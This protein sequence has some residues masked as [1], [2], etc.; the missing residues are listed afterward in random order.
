MDG[1]LLVKIFT[2]FETVLVLFAVF[3][4]IA[5][6]VFVQSQKHKR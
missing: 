6:L 3:M 2:S 4:A 5:V 1:G